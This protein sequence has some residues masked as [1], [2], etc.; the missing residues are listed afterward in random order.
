MLGGNNKNALTDLWRSENQGNIWY[1]QPNLPFE[2][3]EHALSK[4][5][6]DLFVVEKDHVWKSVDQGINWEK[7]LFEAEFGARTGFGMG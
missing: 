6:N 3:Y 4:V 7:V 2:F 5:K 1:R